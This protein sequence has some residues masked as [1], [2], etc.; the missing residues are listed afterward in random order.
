MQFPIPG[1]ADWGFVMVR[2]SILASLFAAIIFLNYAMAQEEGNQTLYAYATYFVCSPD[3][4]SRAD[5][6]INSSFRPHYDAAVE[7]GD[8][9]GWS[10]MQHFVGGSWRRVLVITAQD[11]DSILDAS[12][13]LGEI[14]EDQTPEAGRAFSGI[15]SSHED[16]IWEAVE[17]VGSGNNPADR[18]TVG[19]TMYLQCDLN[20]EDEADE[21]MR[22]TIGPVYDR[23]VGN[24][25][26]AS[27]N[28]LKHNVGGK[29]R[30]ILTMTSSDHKTLMKTRAAI[31]D[32]FDDRRVERALKEMNE[33]CHTHRDYMWDILIQSP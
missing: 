16:Y 17:G 4:E 30:R 6:I 19:F 28:W 12:G 15:C 11:M 26:L 21:I 1:T 13:A 22:E 29:Y 10:W 32:E 8:I 3:G 27:W 14:I 25:G 24:K 33:I 20:R 2:F 23:H 7:H 9:L 31:I 5:E 18:G